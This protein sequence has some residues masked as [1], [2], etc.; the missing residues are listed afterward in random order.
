MI[1]RISNALHFIDPNDRDV[2]LTMGMAIKSELGEGGFD[3]WLDWSKAAASF[4]TKDAQDV[5]KSIR[6]HG[7]V[8]IGSLF[9]QAKAN[10]WT[11]SGNRPSREQLAKLKALSV[12]RAREDELA[13]EHERAET[14]Q[15]AKTIL[16]EATRV[17]SHPYLARK[18]VKPISSLKTLDVGRIKELL[19]YTPQ[20]SSELLEGQLLV[21]PVVRDGSLSTLELI[22]ERGR[23]T[24]LAGR[25]TR[26]GG[27]WAT[28]KL[29][30]GTILIGEGVATVLSAHQA[31][32][33]PG[34]A[35]LSA[36]NL[37]KVT[38]TIRE[39]F[40]D[41]ELI[42][43]A[44]LDKSG[45]PHPKALQASE[46]GRLAVPVFED[47]EPEQ[48]DFNDMHVASGLDSV[49]EAI[50]DAARHSAWPAPQ[51][52]SIELE[53][54]PY[55]LDALP[56]AIRAAVEEVANFVKAP[57]PLVASSAI[58]SLSVAGQS[59]VDVKRAERLQGP[60]SLF[61]L[62]IADSGE[63]KSTCDSFFSSPIRS[64]QEER[65]AELQPAIERYTSNMEAWQAEAE[66]IKAAIKEAGKKGKPTERLRADLAD[67]HGYKPKAPLI[68]RILLGDETPESLAWS[69][70]K[71][72]PSVGVVSSEAGTVLGA[73]GMGKESVMRN[74]ALLNVLWDGGTHTVGRRSS[75]S[76]A[77]KNARLTVALQIQESTLRE[78]FARSGG[79]ARGTGFLARFMVAWPRSTQGTRAFTESPKDWP[80]LSTFHAR[81]RAL[82]EKA[83]PMNDDGGLE[84]DLLTFSPDAKTAWIKF[85]DAIEEELYEGG[86]LCDVRDVA[87]KIADN[88]AR[89]AGLFHLFDPENSGEIS[90]STFEGAS[91]IAAWHLNESRRFFGELALTPDLSDAVRLDTWL[92]EHCSKIQADQISKRDAQQRSPLRDRGRLSKAL[93][94]LAAL[95]RLKIVRHGRSELI[96]LNPAL[97]QP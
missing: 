29:E 7:A 90:L 41:A 72:W 5:W 83:I 25:G 19:G 84:P 50:R 76:F 93:E 46:F 28:N 94:E 78:F 13:I 51:H 10:G 82:L 32:G 64:F 88:A 77:V 30:G 26:S 35:A 55:P 56:E 14:A 39:R 54:E 68:P 57:L 6:P 81:L 11:D 73:H 44:D 74:L 34:V 86:E 70:A 38:Q 18:Q 75:E 16:S 33:F 67:L 65:I 53:P 36:D 40:N 4:N 58:A 8:T 2:W 59:Y 24:A 96:Q 95:D 92:I 61:L 52:L 20:A 87:S 27:Y 79:L 47:R 69:L 60:T 43:L 9:H 45:S 3:T 12:A 63:R 21:V 62:T 15:K 49:K 37:P 85:H 97:V 22:D 48:T 17:E 71:G 91:R 66:G 23:K 89:L 31:T 42:I 80:R 1:E